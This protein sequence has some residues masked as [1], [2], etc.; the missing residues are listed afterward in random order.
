MFQVKQPG[1]ELVPEIQFAP[2]HIS[3]SSLSESHVWIHMSLVTT[4]PGDEGD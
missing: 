1:C 2:V 4:D 3:T